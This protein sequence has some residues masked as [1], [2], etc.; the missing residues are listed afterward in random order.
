[1]IAS[2]QC[3]FLQLPNELQIRILGNLSSQE[4][5][6]ASAVRKGFRQRESITLCVLNAKRNKQVCQKWMQLAFDGSLW[7]KI[8]VRPFY[9]S[10]PADQLLRLGVAAGKFLKVANLR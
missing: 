8:D 3:F 9:S 4:L 6:K 2:Q 5:L 7:T 10:I 1:M